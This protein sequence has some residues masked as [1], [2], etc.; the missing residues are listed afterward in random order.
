[1]KAFLIIL[2]TMFLTACGGIEVRVVESKKLVLLE[3]DA[4]YLEDCDDEVPPSVREYLEMGVDEREDAVVRSLSKQ[5]KYSHDCTIDKR[6]LRA[7]IAK[8]KE[9]LQ[10]HNAKEEARV[11]AYKAQLEKSQHE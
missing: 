1:M 2:A 5:Y 10:E 3:P 8:Q 11:Q 9:V 4:I 6:S 7:L